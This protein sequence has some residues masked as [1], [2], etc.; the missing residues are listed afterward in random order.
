MAPAI[1]VLDL[2]HKYKREKPTKPD[3]FLIVGNPTMPLVSLP[4]GSPPQ[5]LDSLPGAEEEAKAIAKLLKA[6]AII[7]NEARKTSILEKMP[8]AK[9]IH[10]A[11]HGLLDDFKGLG[12]PGAIA[13]AP[14][15]LKPGKS[16]IGDGLLTASEILDLK[17]TANLVVLSACDTGKG[18]I[19]GDGVIGLSRSLISAGASSVL[20][21]LWAVSDEAT[22]YLMTEFYREL[23]INPDKA[24]ALRNSILKTMSKYPRLQEW[25]PFTFI[26]EAD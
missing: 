12:I 19:S 2:T 24:I 17:L 25:A 21:S 23:L 26:G 18:R 8:R 22:A 13:L 10:L 6:K 16:E 5:Q 3:D 9:L 15:S 11:T 7:G 4:V 1:Q 14:D 20:V